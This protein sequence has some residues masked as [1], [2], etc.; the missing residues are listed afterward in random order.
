[1]KKILLIITSIILITGCSIKNED[2]L[3]D[4]KD[5]NSKKETYE[6]T[7]IMKLRSNEDEYKYDLLVQVLD[8]EYF[9]VSLTNKDN[10]HEQIILKNDDGVFV[11]TPELNK[12]FKFSSEWPNNSSQAYLISSLVNDVVSSTDSKIETSNDGYIIKTKVN[13]PNNQKLDYEK[14]YT[15]NKF[16]IN[17]V[18]IYNKDDIVELT[19]EVKDI[20]YNKKIKEMDFSLDNYITEKEESCV[21]E[22]VEG[23]TC[24]NTC[25]DEN[26]SNILDDIIYPLYIPTDTYL[27]G[28]DVVNTENGNRV[29]LTFEGLDPF[30]LVEEVSKV[31]DEMNIIPVNGEPLFLSSSVGAISDNSM[32]WNYL[33]VDYYLTSKTLSK[34]EMMTIAESIQNNT[35]LVAV[36]K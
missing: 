17:K 8:N 13:Y 25:S 9:K 20:K 22:C 28:K 26:V 2:T 35:N 30:I 24:E 1:M 7:G 27:S 12:S 33:G 32:Y 19:V 11:V 31:H 18:E 16:N 15:D 29:I 21:S 34:E 6:L 10:N 4:F 3:K 5:Y 14:I 23:E 36:T